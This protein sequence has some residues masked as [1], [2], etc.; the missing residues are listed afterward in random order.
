MEIASNVEARN[1]M[2]SELSDLGK[3]TSLDKALA[4]GPNNSSNLHKIQL[5]QIEKMTKPGSKGTRPCGSYI[6]SAAKLV[7]GKRC[8]GIDLNKQRTV[9][10]TKYLKF[11][12]LVMKK[13]RILWISPG[14]WLNLI[15]MNVE[16]TLGA[17]W[18]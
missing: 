18:E 9:R 17:Y 8:V 11:V 7:T 12:L 2:T 16:I 4:K 5:Q 6:I 10:Q 14:C 1:I 13:S 15:P 3:L